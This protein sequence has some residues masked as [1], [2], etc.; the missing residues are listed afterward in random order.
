MVDRNAASI[1]LLRPT[2]YKLEA[3]KFD[4]EAENAKL[5]QK[6][7]ELAAVKKSVFVGNQSN[8]LAVLTQKRRDLAF[9]AQ[10]LAI[11]ETQLASSLKT[12]SALLRSGAQAPGQPH[13][14]ADARA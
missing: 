9:D 5:S 1:D 3:A 10:R 4:K 7:A 6:V 14:R 11:E 13:G 12:Q 2:Q 8:S